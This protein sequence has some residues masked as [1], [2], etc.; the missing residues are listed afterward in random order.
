MRWVALVIFG[1]LAGQTAPQTSAASLDPVLGRLAEASTD[2]ER[3]QALDGVPEAARDALYQACR[4]RGQAVFTRHDY[5]LGLRYFRAALEVARRMR[6][7]ARMA[8]AWRGVG[9]CLYWEG[10]AD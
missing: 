5:A 8:A 7:P 10:K 2:G 4:E 1:C 3:A 6:Q 9:L